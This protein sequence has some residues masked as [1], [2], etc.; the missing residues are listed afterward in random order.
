MTF[1]TPNGG[2]IFIQECPITSNGLC[3]SHGHCHYDPVTKSPYCYCNEGHYGSS[4][5][6]TSL[7]VLKTYDGFSVQ[8]GLLITLLII[9]LALVGVVGFLVYRLTLFKKASNEYGALSN[10]SE[11]VETVHF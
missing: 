2:H 7:P 4:C 3:N 6:E 5:S 8:L 10:G 1:H 9:A 11:M